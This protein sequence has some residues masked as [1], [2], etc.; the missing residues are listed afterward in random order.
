METFNSSVNEAS[1]SETVVQSPRTSHCR[2]LHELLLSV[3]CAGPGN[4]VFLPTGWHCL[5]ECIFSA[6]INRT[7]QL[8]AVHMNTASFPAGSGRIHGQS[9]TPR[10]DQEQ[11]SSLPSHQ[12]RKPGRSGFMFL[13]SR[14]GRQK[15]VRI[16]SSEGEV[17][18]HLQSITPCYWNQHL[19]KSFKKL[20]VLSKRTQ[21]TVCT[22]PDRTRGIWSTQNLLMTHR[23][24]HLPSTASLLLSLSTFGTSFIITQIVKDFPK[25]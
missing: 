24:V 5:T 13:P 2:L 7:A 20:V 16:S 23:P 6:L 19:R 10:Q 8:R 21:G 14:A 1:F 3:R 4:L 25:H 22:V 18:H 11:E 9:V 15:H 17:N 12:H